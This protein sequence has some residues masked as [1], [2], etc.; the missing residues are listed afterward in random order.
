MLINN[1]KSLHKFLN[2]LFKCRYLLITTHGHFWV[3]FYGDT[4]RLGTNHKPRLKPVHCQVF[5]GKSTH[6]IRPSA[7]F[8]WSSFKLLHTTIFVFKILGI[9]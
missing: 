1:N 5:N 3:K 2:I 4:I 7:A 6:N 8:I 9:N